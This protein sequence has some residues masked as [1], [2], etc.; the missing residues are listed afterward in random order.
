MATMAAK[1]KTATVRTRDAALRAADWAGQ[2]VRTVPGAAGALMLAYGLGQAWRP[3]FWVTLG[4]FA[5]AMD[6]RMA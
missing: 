5:L 1:W 6:R 2:V 3:L 4:V